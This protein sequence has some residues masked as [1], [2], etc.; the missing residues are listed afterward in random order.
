MPKVIGGSLVAHR[1][2][3][4]A[5][6][7]AALR[8]QLYERGF[9][10]VTLSR[11]AAAAGVGRTS[12]YN[13]FPDRQSLLVAFVEHE[14]QRYVSDLD[15]GMRAAGSPTERLAVFAR[16]QLQ[17]LSEFH[18]PPGQALAGALDPSAYRRIAAHA[19]PIT[20]RLAA[21]VAD[22]VAAGEMAAGDPDVLVAMVSAALSAR[23]IVDV[24][25][26]ELPASI[27]SAVAVVRR[28]VSADGV[29]GS[30]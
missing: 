24:P 26:D 15:A 22:G 14:A 28:M 9:G 17:R 30:L 25:A 11:V 18:L 29:A 19:D 8:E 23:Q 6:V 16:M 27:E 7:F 21:I 10:S 12:I 3:V 1:G 13:H 20:G 4:R 2:E 5:R